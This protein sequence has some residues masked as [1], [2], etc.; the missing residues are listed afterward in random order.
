MNLERE[1]YLNSYQR[2]LMTNE[3]NRKGYL[4][5]STNQPNNKISSALR[6]IGQIRGIHIH[7]SFDWKEPAEQ[8]R[9]AN[10]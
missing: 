5:A 8:M 10:A 1:A 9:R 3:C 7:V 4:P 2:Q 6:L